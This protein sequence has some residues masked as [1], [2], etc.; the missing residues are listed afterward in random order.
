MK[1][2]VRFY[3]RPPGRKRHTVCEAKVY[4]ADE[5]TLKTILRELIVIHAEK[6]E[7]TT[8]EDVARL[9]VSRIKRER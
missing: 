5:E 6:I 1:V 3:R 4:D 8:E 9:F 7:V 2:S